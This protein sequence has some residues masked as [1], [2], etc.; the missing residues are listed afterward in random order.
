MQEAL[1]ALKGEFMCPSRM[2]HVGASA[3]RN[4]SG[5]QKKRMGGSSR[6]RSVPVTSGGASTIPA[7]SGR[8]VT[9]AAT[10]QAAS[11]GGRRSVRF[12]AIRG[13]QV[14]VQSLACISSHIYMHGD[15]LDALFCAWQGQPRGQHGPPRGHHRAP[16]FARF[17][18][19]LVAEEQAMAP[20]PSPQVLD[21]LA[22]AAG[23]GVRIMDNQYQHLR[24]SIAR[25]RML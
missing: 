14:L 13:G 22:G 17:A 19:S 1:R 9:F 25:N 18:Q 4:R 11:E 10:P 8:R 3:S 6:S 12:P 21:L 5:P 20:H 7:P 15:C 16:N 23:A 2:I 24:A